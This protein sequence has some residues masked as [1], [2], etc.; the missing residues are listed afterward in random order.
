MSGPP[1]YHSL[2][3]SHPAEPHQTDQ[4]S[5]D[6]NKSLNLNIA[7]YFINTLAP[8]NFNTWRHRGGPSIQTIDHFCLNPNHQ[9]YVE[10]TWKTV[11]SCIEQ[12]D[13]YTGRNV[14]KQHGRPYLLSSYYEIN[15]LANS[16]QNRLGLRYT[17]LLIHFHRQKHG[18]NA[19]SRS[20]VNLDFRIL[21]P[22]ITKNQ[23]IKQG[24]KNEGKW[25]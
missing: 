23:I 6:L 4:R 20:T 19:V 10:N 5:L 17:T 2:L 11:I 25:K 7:S 14:T 1:K 22:K 12:E 8:P 16:M 15:L 21:Q 18:D 13:K 3:A 24:T 9:R